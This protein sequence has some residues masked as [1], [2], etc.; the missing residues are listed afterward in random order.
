MLPEGSNEYPILMSLVVTTGVAMGVV[1][2]AVKGVV[3]GVNTCVAN[4][5][6]RKVEI[7]G[8]N[9]RNI[10]FICY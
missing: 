9:L 10:F 2:V 5:L 3:E 1:T 6:K 7:Y 4:K 8:K